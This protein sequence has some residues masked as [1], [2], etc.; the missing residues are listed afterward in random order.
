MPKVSAADIADLFS[1][2][3]DTKDQVKLDASMKGYNDFKK[4]LKAFDPQLKR[5]MDREIRAFLKPVITDA[6][7]M[8]PGKPL[9]GWREG[10]GRGADNGSGKLPNWEQTAVQK[11]IVVRQGTMRRRRP[12][13]V[14]VSAWQLRNTDGA[15]SAFEGMGRR[16]GRTERGRIMIAAMTL[17]HG[18]EPRLLWRAWG[19]AGG[20]KKLVTG[21]TEIVL[22]HQ[23]LLER[24]MKAVSA[25]KD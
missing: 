8:V 4:Q 13:E 10:S 22:R 16:G 15:G 7:S 23:A 5:D 9:S 25:S 18:K 14:V 20:D 12:G 17:Y 11:G 21:V 19:D 1:R 6:K 24:R 3:P 2:P